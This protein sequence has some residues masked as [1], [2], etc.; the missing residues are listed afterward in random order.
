MRTS[1]LP[2]FQRIPY[3]LILSGGAALGKALFGGKQGNATGEDIYQKN[4]WLRQSLG[5]AQQ[6]YNGRMAGAPQLENNIYKNQ[7]NTIGTIERNATDGAQ[8]LALATATQGTTN[9][10][11]TQLAIQEAQDKAQKQAQ[12]QTAYGNMGTAYNQDMQ[13]D[14]QLKEAGSKN[15]FGGVN[16]LASILAMLKVG[17]GGKAP[18]DI[19]GMNN[20]L[21]SIKFV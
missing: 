17:Q 7:S 12:L 11:L 13:R 15:L 21:S 18:I 8:A 14:M 6:Y 16:D 10:A 3:G 1:F 19:A 5:L 9:D 2:Q 4:P 20:A